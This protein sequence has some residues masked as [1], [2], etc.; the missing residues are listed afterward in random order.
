MTEYGILV[1][2]T[3]G[4]W[5]GG[6]IAFFL[7]PL[8]T[9]GIGPFLA[10]VL[11]VLGVSIAIALWL[12]HHSFRREIKN[13]IGAIK[14]FKNEEE[15]FDH[16]E[17]INKYFKNHKNTHEGLSECW[18]EFSETI[19]HPHAPKS[20]GG[21]PVIRNTSRPFEFFDAQSAGF[22]TPNLR[23]WPNIF[24][25]LGLVLTFA[26]LI[27]SLT[28][29]SQG[30]EGTTEDIQ[31]VLVELLQ[32]TSAKFYTSLMALA[33]SIGLT[34][35]LRKLE[36]RRDYLFKRLADKI[37]RGMQYVSVE[38]IALQQL[39]ELKEQKEQLQQFNT[40]LAMQLGGHIEKAITKA[41]NPV[42]ET[43]KGI[44]QGLKEGA[45]EIIKDAAGESLNHLS[46]RL[47]TLTDVLGN[48]SANLSKSTGQFEDDI[49]ES[50]KV[51][52]SGMKA[53]TKDL[54]DNA[55]ETSDMLTKKLE[56]LANSLSDASEGIKSKLGQG[57][58]QVSKELNE[59]ISK[60]A[61]ATND[62][63]EKMGAAVSGI[64]E[65]V[66]SISTALN[67][68]SKGAAKEA[69]KRVGDAGKSMASALEGSIGGL[70]KGIGGF[71][72]ALSNA[73][74]SMKEMK[75]GLDSTSGVLETA[76]DKIKTSVS[77]LDDASGRMTEILQPALRATE[78]IRSSVKQMDEKITQSANQMSET[79]TELK[80]EMHRSSEAWE[81][82]S[83]KFD[84]VNEKLSEV[85]ATVNGQIEENQKSVVEFVTK[86]DNSFRGA[87]AALSGAIDELA[88]ERKGP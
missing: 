61:K 38:D 74:D 75:S 58:E 29:A 9:E 14:E 71:E 10:L 72:E 69:E 43:L 44:G 78:G 65:A 1:V 21:T 16:Y 12:K 40:D 50:L 13:A 48:L 80:Q 62:S 79:L 86:L 20:D 35:L 49:V 33:V 87:I 8:K 55:S 73:T 41:M 70:S 37:E 19:I 39:T 68:A 26:G 2:I 60:L 32:T 76:S 85:F 81:T 82:H 30:M 25:G 59:S 56:K 5:F 42:A 45:G 52:Q 22:T 11:I 31:N 23:I 24:V 46:D 66:A 4:K 27:V 6:L 77:K 15:F 67:D 64:N 54:Q 47:A 3:L 34:L 36:S 57:A 88:D 7:N 63:A 51:M 28:I 53:M 17:D 84:G 18:R 83:E